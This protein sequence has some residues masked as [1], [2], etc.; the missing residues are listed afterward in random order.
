MNL[1]EF[2]IEKRKGIPVTHKT[3]PLSR[4]I[5]EAGMV[6]IRFSNPNGNLYYISKNK[7]SAYRF[8]VEEDRALNLINTIKAS[9]RDK[10]IVID[11]NILPRS[12]YFSIKAKV[13]KH[14][15]PEEI[16]MP[17]DGWR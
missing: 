1:I 11:S 2:Y 16:G 9:T 8:V 10:Y 5:H 13:I 6:F 17:E 3:Y 12:E 15:N 7:Y 4:E 14:L